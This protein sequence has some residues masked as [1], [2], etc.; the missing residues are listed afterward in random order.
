METKGVSIN[1]YGK[2]QQVGFRYFVFKLASEVGVKGFVKNMPDGSVY[3]EAEGD[4]HQV[5]VFV[6]HCKIGPPHSQVT[7]F[8]VVSIPEQDFKEFTIR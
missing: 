6:E 8:N 2:V 1:L 3:V 4:P 7:R 5:D